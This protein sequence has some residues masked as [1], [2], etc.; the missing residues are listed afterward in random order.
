MALEFGYRLGDTRE[1]IWHQ[2]AALEPI[3]PDVLEAWQADGEASHLRPYAK[4]GEEP[5]IITMRT[6]DQDQA[7]YVLGLYLGGDGG[8]GLVRAWLAAFRLGVGFE[9]IGEKIGGHSVYVR[10]H[11]FRMLAEP[12]VAYL[13]RKYTGIVSF[14]GKLIYDSAFASESEKKAS[15]PPSTVTQSSVAASTKAADTAP[16]NEAA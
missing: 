16:S 9:G 14:Y 8:P 3:P 2:D 4:P 13:A 1:S 5:T 15:S 7:H 12:F 11:G 6:L 10:E